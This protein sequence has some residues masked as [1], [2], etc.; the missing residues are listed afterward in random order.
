[1]NMFVLHW[2]MQIRVCQHSF[3]SAFHIVSLCI[4]VTI[5]L[6][7]LRVSHLHHERVKTTLERMSLKEI[8]HDRDEM[9]STH[10]LLPSDSS[11]RPPPPPRSPAPKYHSLLLHSYSQTNATDHVDVN[12][13]DTKYYKRT[14]DV[15]KSSFFESELARVG[16]VGGGGGFFQG[17]I[18]QM[19]VWHFLLCKTL[20]FPLLY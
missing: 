10:P 7:V 2:L 12:L 3:L 8:R 1:M 11:P 19:C 15:K 18:C 17:L 4:I 14:K 5:W 13:I 20:R 9:T 6:Q 16:G